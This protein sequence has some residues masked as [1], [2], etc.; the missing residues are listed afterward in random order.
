MEDKSK[1]SV[2]LTAAEFER[3]A[4]YCVAK[5]YKKST[6]I[7]RLIREHMEDE[8]FRPRTPT[9]SRGSRPAGAGLAGHDRRAR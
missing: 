2:V 3:F 4:A 8:G 5:G 9:T 1:I 7:V 6:L